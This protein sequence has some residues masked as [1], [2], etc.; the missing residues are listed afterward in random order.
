MLLI[1]RDFKNKIL[2]KL[3]TF[4]FKSSFLS[5]GKNSII[6]NRVKVIGSKNISI[7][8]GVHISEN[9]WLNA[10]KKSS[11]NSPSLEIGNNTYIGR[12][13]Q[14][15]AWKNVKIG[16]NVLIADRVFISDADHKYKNK[17]MPIKDQGD[18][19][20]SAVN[21]KDGSWIGINSVI[22]PGVTIGKNAIVA[23]NS[24]VI[25]DVDDYSIVGGNPAKV[26]KEY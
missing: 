20:K 25:N 22:M 2:I 4:F 8:E 9:I 15:N 14:I 6:E 1:I 3:I 23:A 16:E 5:F 7:G 18:E 26:I 17:D 10:N 13:T 19:Y 11:D 21:I 24:V 12:M